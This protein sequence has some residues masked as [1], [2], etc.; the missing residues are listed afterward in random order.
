MHGLTAVRSTIASESL[1]QLPSQRGCL[2]SRERTK[3]TWLVPGLVSVAFLVH[4]EQC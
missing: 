3:P 2:D 4:L 1:Y